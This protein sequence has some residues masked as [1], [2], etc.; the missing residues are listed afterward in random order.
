MIGRAP[1]VDLELLNPFFAQ[2]PWTQALA[3]RKV[4]VVHPFARTIE[5]QYRK[6]QL[7]F[8]R[9]MLPE[10]ELKTIRAVQ[11]IAGERTPFTTWFAALQSMQDADGRRGLRHLAWSAAAPMASRW[12]RMPSG[13]AAR[14]CTWAAACS[15]C[16][17]FAAIAGRT[18]RYHDVYDYSRLMNEH[19]VRPDEQERPRRAEQVEDACYW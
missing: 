3:G 8:E 6:R 19:W 16:S 17:A 1:K 14:P 12:P 5:A 9:E 10:F 13:A 18:P 2:R 11:S 4:L 15:C 7:L